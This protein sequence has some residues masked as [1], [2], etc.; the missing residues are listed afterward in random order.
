VLTWLIHSGTNSRR[1][2]AGAAIAE[3]D[4]QSLSPLL[5]ELGSRFILDSDAISE[6]C[7]RLVDA[8]S[9]MACDLLA[10]TAE[11]RLVPNEALG[12]NFVS[13]PAL[14][15]PLTALDEGPFS[16]TVAGLA[17]ATLLR[18]GRDPA[19]GKEPAGRALARLLHSDN[20]LTRI[21]AAEAMTDLDYVDGL[22]DVNEAKAALDR[23]GMVLGPYI[24]AERAALKAAQEKLG[25][26]AKKLLDARAFIAG[27]HAAQAIKLCDEIINENP[28][29]SVTAEAE[30][31][32][33]Q[34][35][36]LSAPAA[37]T[38]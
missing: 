2:A 38:P 12:D 5:S 8:H 34:A 30:A 31:L 35:Q 4:L 11:R 20:R 27:G 18:F 24:P 33:A 3:G 23:L 22:K 21:C 15:D 13:G 19:I 29:P 28:S 36:K 14:A 37:T 7:L 1:I 9:L 6:L 26:F 16:R 25:R 32:K 10:R 17:C